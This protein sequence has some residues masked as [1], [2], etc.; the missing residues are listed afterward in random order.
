MTLLRT[1]RKAMDEWRQGP[2]LP[3]TLSPAIRDEL[4]AAV[5]DPSRRAA[6]LQDLGMVRHCEDHYEAWVVKS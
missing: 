3:E 1:I 6:I 5:K 4:R 2:T